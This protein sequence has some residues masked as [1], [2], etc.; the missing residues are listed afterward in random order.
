[1]IG[2][3]TICL[4]LFNEYNSHRY[5]LTML[6]CSEFVYTKLSLYECYFERKY[7]ASEELHY[8]MK[9]YFVLFEFLTLEI[10]LWL[11]I[12][13]ILQ[14]N[15]SQLPLFVISLHYYALH[16]NNKENQMIINYS[17]NKSICFSGSHHGLDLKGPRKLDIWR[18]E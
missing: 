16:Y 6:G 12:S 15:L 18:L 7:S 2:K 17:S 3:E 9:I 11:D 1:M 13:N 5:Y 4:I 8:L 10:R 14:K